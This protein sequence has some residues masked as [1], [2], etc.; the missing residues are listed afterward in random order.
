MYNPIDEHIIEKWLSGE[1]SEAERQALEQHPDFPE[2]KRIMDTS[3]SWDA[4]AFDE[5]KLWNSLDEEMKKDEEPV[6]QQAKVRKFPIGYIAL[7]LAAGIAALF[8][9]FLPEV[10][11][12]KVESFQTKAGEMQ[13]FKLPDGSQVALNAVSGI[14]FDT[15]GWQKKRELVLDG[16]A[17][18]SVKKG[19]SFIVKTANGQ[20]RVLG[21]EFNV[22]A[23]ESGFEVFC[24][25]G[26][27]E[28]TAPNGEQVILTAGQGSQWFDKQ[29]IKNTLS[30]HQAPQWQQKKLTFM[31]GSFERAVAELD[32][33][34]DIE[35]DAKAFKNDDFRSKRIPLEDAKEAL[36]FLVSPYNGKAIWLSEKQ[37]K[38]EKME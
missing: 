5:A 23:R 28:V 37:V 30:K 26:K 10:P 8:L 12:S 11:V 18:F 29:L 32:R 1:L 15:V 2:I 13:E 6:P 27:V 3:A 24:Y 33:Y 20:V 9:I 16:E 7:G 19:E 17:T 36:E 34:F 38:L 31:G 21:T 25:E 14:A 35:I 22:W 4:P